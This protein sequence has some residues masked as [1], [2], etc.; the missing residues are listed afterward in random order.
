VI[1]S[2]E[3]AQIWDEIID[4]DP[5]IPKFF[6]NSEHGRELCRAWIFMGQNLIER[7]GYTRA[8]VA[9]FGR[10]FCMKHLARRSPIDEIWDA[11]E[12]HVEELC[13]TPDEESN[14]RGQH[15]IS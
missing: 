13:Q 4:A 6:K 5:K 2:E 12:S 9:A 10:R 14:I 8:E 7:A 1:Y 15:E 3:Q 11:A